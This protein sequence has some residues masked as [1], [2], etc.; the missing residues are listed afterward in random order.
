MDATVV[1]VISV[2]I[3][4]A[5]QKDKEISYISH[6]D[7]Q[8]T[9]QRAFRR[10]DLPL[11]YTNGFNPHPKLSFAT[12]LATGFSSSGEWID[13]ELDSD[14]DPQE[15][16]KRVNAVLPSGLHF[17]TA[18]E[19]DGSIDTLSKIL[20]AATYALQLFPHTPVSIEQLRD[21]LDSLLSEQEIIVQKKTK[22]GIKPTNIRPEIIEAFVTETPDSILQIEL[23]GSL[24]VSGGLR[25]ETF[26]SAL[27]DRIGT[28]GFS[29][30]HRIS[31][32]FTGTEKLPRLK[33]QKGL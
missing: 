20:S 32:C 4:A 13:L 2:R 24:T 10:A 11:S 1:L 18:F 27:F 23:T 15:F 12:A 29:E 28:T 5:F 7:V 8:R 21:A 25:V 6:L 33:Y 26:L 9:L 16:L 19:A 17:H 31:V 30:V 22:G 14:L 3:I